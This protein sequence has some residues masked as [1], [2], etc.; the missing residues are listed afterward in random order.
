MRWTWVCCQCL[1]LP[2]VTP[3]F[4]WTQSA[5]ALWRQLPSHTAPH[6]T[7][8]PLILWARS[9]YPS[10]WAANRTRHSLPA[11]ALTACRCGCSGWP[12]LLLFLPQTRTLPA[13]LSTQHTALAWRE[14][15]QYKVTYRTMSCISVSYWPSL[16]P[17]L[18][19]SQLIRFT[20][21]GAMHLH[22]R[23]MTF[24]DLPDFFKNVFP[25]KILSVWKTSK[26][27]KI[28]LENQIWEF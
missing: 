21:L 26:Q 22:A 19:M 8:S 16:H 27:K 3:C 13:A 17:S 15:I 28:N 9:S 10:M 6:L 14:I 18:S 11:R 7:L 24:K 25:G 5:A 4:V 23:S 2:S 20:T 12:V 1:V